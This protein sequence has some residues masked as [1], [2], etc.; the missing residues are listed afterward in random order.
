M[1]RL[2]C[3]ALA[4]SA[5]RHTTVLFH[6]PAGVVTTHVD[7]LGRPTVYE[8]LRA[9]LP[10]PLRALDWHACGRLD[11]NTSGLLVLTTD[12]A[13]V[14]HVTNP[15]AG[16]AA[17]AAAG[18]AP[19]PTKVEKEY[20]ALCMGALDDDALD[21]LRAGV[22][23][24]GGLGRSSRARV[25]RAEPPESLPPPSPPSADAPPRCRGA[26][27]NTWLRI[28]I[29]EGKNRQVRLRRFARLTKMCFSTTE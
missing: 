22:E 17:A 11:L 13:L 24:G 19:P 18:G 6:K 8:S 7:E 20:R 16:R 4:S 2:L 29:A 9:A 28:V 10:P 3:L 23:L 27:R 21:A 5:G 14:H 12:G 26:P 1:R 15:T 25:Q